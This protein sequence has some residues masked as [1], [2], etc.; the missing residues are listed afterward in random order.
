MSEMDRLAAWRDYDTFGSLLDMRDGPLGSYG[1]VQ[2]FERDGK[3]W[4]RMVRALSDQM[5]DIEIQPDGYMGEIRYA[6][7]ETAPLPEPP[8]RP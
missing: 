1:T 8:K 3:S 5:I 4:V 7:P 2:Y 6:D